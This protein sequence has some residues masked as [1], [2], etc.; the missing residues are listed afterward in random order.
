VHGNS[1]FR[2]FFG[3][4]AGPDLNTPGFRG[5]KPG[6]PFPSRNLGG[7]KDKIRKPMGGSWCFGRATADTV[8]SRWLAVKCGVAELPGRHPWRAILAWMVEPVRTKHHPFKRGA[9]K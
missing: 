7:S 3:M 1:Y 8:E 2:G 4:G 6:G 5:E 9:G